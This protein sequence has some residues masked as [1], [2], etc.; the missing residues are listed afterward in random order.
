MS[1]QY[2]YDTCPNCGH[3]TSSLDRH[4]SEC[5]AQTAHNERER[6]MAAGAS[7]EMEKAMGPEF[8]PNGFSSY[9]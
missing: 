1:N 2:G 7:R 9:P 4:L 8:D 3:Y 5:R 6:E